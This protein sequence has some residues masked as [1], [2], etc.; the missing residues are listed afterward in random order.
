M[1]K[2]VENERE[3]PNIAILWIVGMSRRMDILHKDKECVEL[4]V[5]LLARGFGVT[6]HAKGASLDDALQQDPHQM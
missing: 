4:V 3:V 2:T 5:R 1:P 6:S